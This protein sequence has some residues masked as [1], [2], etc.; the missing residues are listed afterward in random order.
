[1]L[2][3]LDLVQIDTTSIYHMHFYFFYFIDITGVYLKF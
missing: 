2:G 1:M 3:F